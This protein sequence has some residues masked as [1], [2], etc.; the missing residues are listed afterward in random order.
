MELIETVDVVCVCV[1]V[2]VC[3]RPRAH[4]CACVHALRIVS[5]DTILR[6]IN[7]LII[8]INSYTSPHNDK[9]I[10][11]ERYNNLYKLHDGSVSFT[12]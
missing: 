9:I 10:D 12:C 5:I 2:C 4:A 6:F 3:V 7:T 1:C 11:V 8:I